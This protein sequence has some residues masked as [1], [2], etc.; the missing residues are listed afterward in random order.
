MHFEEKSIDEYYD[1]YQEYLKNREAERLAAANALSNA[2]ESDHIL[3]GSDNII[4]KLKDDDDNDD[5]KEE[6]HKEDIDLTED[7]RE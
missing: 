5:D 3:A 1:Q 7:E 6:S 4:V 2:I